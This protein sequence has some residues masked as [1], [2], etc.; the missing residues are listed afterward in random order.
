MRYQTRMILYYATI[1]ILV[2]LILGIFSYNNSMHYEKLSQNNGLIIESRSLISQ[3]EDRFSRMDAIM[4]YVLSDPNVLSSITMLGRSKKGEFSSATL[5]NAQR[6][7]EIGI[8][9]D[10]ILKNSYRTV[11]YNQNGYLISSFIN[12]SMKHLKTDLALDQYAYISAAEAANGKSIIAAP[13]V[14]Q[15]GTTDGETVYSLV[16]SLQGYRMGYLEIENTVSSLSSL[17][18]S[19][20]NI[21]FM[22][23][24]ND[25]ELLYSSTNSLFTEDLKEIWKATKPGTIN[26]QNGYLYTTSTSSRYSLSVLCY[27]SDAAFYA[28]KKTVFSTAV[29]SSLIVFSLSLAAII[30]WSYILVKPVKHLTKI[31]ENTSLDHLEYE[32]GMTAQEYKLDEFNALARTYQD[33]TTRLQEALTNEKR[34]SMLSLQAQFDSLQAQVNPHFIYNVLNI[35]SSEGVISGNENISEM[36]SSLASMLRYSTGNTERYASVNDELEYLN[37][38][39]YLLK[40]RYGEKID[41]D[42]QIDEDIKKEI[43]PKSAMQQIVENSVS[44][45]F[46]QNAGCMVITIRGWRTESG[47]QIRFQDN[48]GGFSSQSL[49]DLN[50]NMTHIRK[51][52]LSHNLGIEM[53]IGG[54]GLI[55]AYA[56]C[57]LL[58]Q[59]HLI[60][61]LSNCTFPKTGAIVIIG[62]HTETPAD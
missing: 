52:I 51:N 10:Y 36:C 6:E 22:L 4:N 60:F 44:H 25:G 20:S 59:D 50:K 35:I 9:T 28:A 54:L 15:W 5:Q 62:E 24:S 7:I 46:S 56:R 32:D 2:T 26:H 21:N 13:H 39:F 40:S 48:G 43:L 37:H 19:D 12:P 8:C 29:T 1:A 11:F 18:K 49:D 61:E 42:I 34:S 57:L 41:F 31:I 27:K 14:D 30:L 38:Y 55:N 47:W 17:N 23:I 53:E 33:M 16:K 45:G 58:Y 3:M